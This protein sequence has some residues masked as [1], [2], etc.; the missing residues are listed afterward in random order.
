MPSV[1]S[2]PGSISCLV[3]ARVG[4][5]PCELLPYMN[6]LMLVDSGECVWCTLHAP[7]RVRSDGGAKGES[8]M[9]T[10]SSSNYS[11]RIALAAAV[12]AAAGLRCLV[13]DS[14]LG[15]SCEQINRH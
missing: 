10:R 7:C 3:L 4:C 6:T 13:Y 14:L 15:S 11:Q 5:V 8:E 12:V 2:E 9:L 1:S